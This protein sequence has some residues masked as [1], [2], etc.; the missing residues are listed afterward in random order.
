MIFSV[1]T[2]CIVSMVFFLKNLSDRNA[3]MSQEILL[4]KSQLAQQQLAQIKAEIASSVLL[5]QTIKSSVVVQ[6]S[7]SWIFYTVL[8]FAFLGG[9]IYFSNFD[10]LSG[11][12]KLL[13]LWSKKQTSWPSY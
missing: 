2:G 3:E 10:L 7:T 8:C 4:L 11:F 6:N 13:N 1:I 12:T 9:A 5:Q